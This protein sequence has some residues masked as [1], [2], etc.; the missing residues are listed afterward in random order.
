VRLLQVVLAV[1]TLACFLVGFLINLRTVR[2]LL[3]PGSDV[4][5]AMLVGAVFSGLL[6][7]AFVVVLLM[8][9]VRP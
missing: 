8:L 2:R 3:R 6:C 9:L 4:P 1:V 5:R 7:A